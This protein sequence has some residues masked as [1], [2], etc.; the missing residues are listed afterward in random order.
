MPRVGSPPL[1]RMASPAAFHSSRG[2]QI[3]ALQPTLAKGS[4][5]RVLSPSSS[6]VTTLPG[7]RVLSPSASGAALPNLPTTPA[8]PMHTVVSIGTPTRQMSVASPLTPAAPRSMS[9]RRSITRVYSQR[10]GLPPGTAREHALERMVAEL[11]AQ[12]KQR[13][14]E[15]AEIRGR[16]TQIERSVRPGARARS[17]SGGR[18]N[19]HR[20]GS[21]P[22]P[23]APYVAD[24]TDPVDLRLEDFYNQTDCRVLF[25]RI[26]RG[27]YRFGSTLVELDIVNNKLMARTE[28]G[29]NRGKHGPIEKF[30]RHYE[31][32]EEMLLR[33]AA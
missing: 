20:V 1:L 9:P 28:D 33:R 10:G 31:G 16:M 21:T 6:G 12:V 3:M 15:L 29:W 5:A 2:P 24:D 13:D 25:K 19:L 17:L 27:F 18:S 11:Q 4:S 8:P 30:V 22:E 32:Q 7:S 26:N 23:P 14:E